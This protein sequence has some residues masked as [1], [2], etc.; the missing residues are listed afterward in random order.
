MNKAAIPVMLASIVLLSGRADAAPVPHAASTPSSVTPGGANQRVSLEGCTGQWLFNGVW[1]VRVN[2]VEPITLPNVGN[3]GFA[4]TVQVRNGTPKTTSLAYSGVG[5]TNLV[6]ADG[7]QLSIDQTL[8]RVAYSTM[9]N[10][11]L[12]PGAGLTQVLNYY[13]PTTTPTDQKPA[14]WLVE[15]H[16][17]TTGSH[18]P[19]YTTKTPSLRVK[20]DCD[21]SATSH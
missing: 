4:V 10:T 19:H 8:D 12:V 7:T 20:L 18:P 21:K 6:L 3:P 14:K 9:I 2:K 15:M 13:L 11:D 16:Q 1:R 5:E 17:N